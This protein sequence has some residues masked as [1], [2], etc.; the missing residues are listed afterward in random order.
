MLVDIRPYRGVH[1]PKSMKLVFLL[2][3][4]SVIAQ[5]DFDF[6]LPKRNP[7]IASTFKYTTPK[8]DSDV[9][10]KVFAYTQKTTMTSSTSLTTS[11]DL[12]D[13]ATAS[14]TTPDR[15]KII[16][17]QGNYL[18]ELK[19]KRYG[20]TTPVPSTSVSS[21]LIPVPTAETTASQDYLALADPKTEDGST[22]SNP[23]CVP[24]ELFEDG[25]IPLWLLFSFASLG[26][27]IV[28]GYN[29]SVLKCRLDYFI[30]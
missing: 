22:V 24:S 11:A 29:F 13:R 16:V 26:S 23:S 21:P 30:L 25:C 19:M 8:F 9:Y 28:Y 5:M 20:I 4:V 7:T 6:R 1:L 27:G 14:V 15:R 17:S 10:E 3:V 12:P 2:C 18:R